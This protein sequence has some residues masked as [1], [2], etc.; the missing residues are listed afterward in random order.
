MRHA[1]QVDLRAPSPR[2]HPAA[3]NSVTKLTHTIRDFAARP[4][5][6][7]VNEH[8]FDS[9]EQPGLFRDGFHLER[10]RMHAL[11]R[12]LAREVSALLK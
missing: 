6:L 9:L 3:G 11:L 2:T 8:A 10:R 12:M 1:D 4:G 5:R 7:L